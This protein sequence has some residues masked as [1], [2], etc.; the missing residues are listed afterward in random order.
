MKKFNNKTF[1]RKN[2][3]TLFEL[4]ISVGLLV[5]LSVVLLRTL[6]LTGDYWHKTDEQTQLQSDA[7]TLFGLLSDDLGNLVYA[8]S[9]GGFYAPLHIESTRLCM[10]THNRLQSE[11]DGKAAYSDVSKAVYKFTAPSGSAAGR[12]ERMCSSDAV[13]SG[14]TLNTFDMSST[15]RDT[16]YPATLANKSAVIDNV[17][18]FQAAAYKFQKDGSEYKP[19]KVADTDVFGSAEVRMIHV[20]LVLLPAKYFREYNAISSSDTA[21]RNSFVRKHGRIFYKMF[22]IK[23]TNQ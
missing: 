11:S 23:P 7:K 22:W 18:N 17:V 21:A 10:V 15:A 4:L 6:V 1:I 13:V 20:K 16:F 19:E 12:I 14:D 8:K 3:F 9:N 2:C 5:I